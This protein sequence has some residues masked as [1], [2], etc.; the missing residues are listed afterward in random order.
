MPIIN[1]FKLDYV[2]SQDDA[3]APSL[4]IL[5]ESINTHRYKTEQRF[6]I[7]HY[8]LARDLTIKVPVTEM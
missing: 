7:T 2:N 6:V 1:I 5:G 4:D 8:F 3:Q